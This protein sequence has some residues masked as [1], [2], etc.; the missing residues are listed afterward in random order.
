MFYLL[1]LITHIHDKSFITINVEHHPISSCMLFSSD[2]I[3]HHWSIIYTP[4]IHTRFEYMDFLIE[5][6]FIINYI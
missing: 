4:L 5:F 6:L 1:I 3:D 2:K